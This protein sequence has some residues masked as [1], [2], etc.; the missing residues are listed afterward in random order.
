MEDIDAAYQ[1]AV[2]NAEEYNLDISNSFFSGGSAGT[3]L[4]SL[5]AQRYSKIKAYVGFNGIYNFV[6]NPG[7][8][9]PAPNVYDHCVPSC[10]ANSALFNLRENPPITLLLHGDKDGTI[11]HTQS[12]LFAEAIENAGGTATAIIYEDETHAFFNEGKVQYEDCLFELSKFLKANGIIQTEPVTSIENIKS[13]QIEIYPNPSFDTVYI[14]TDKL[15]GK[16][17]LKLY[18]T[19]GEIVLSQKFNPE[20][21]D[22]FSFSV[23]KIPEGAYVLSLKD[24]KGQR[25]SSKIVV[26][27]KF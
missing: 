11:N 6:E 3:P 22:Y 27:S 8:S 5:A 10:Q 17:K 16:T 15:K 19:K 9:F 23:A 2:H 7:S 24:I 20:S 21:S 18:N 25:F 1:W 13:Q 12:V 4:S 14:K 26:K